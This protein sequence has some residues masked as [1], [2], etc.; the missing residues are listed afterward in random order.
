MNNI[1]T[2]NKLH[3]SSVVLIYCI[4]T[5]F[6]FAAFFCIWPASS[7]FVVYFLLVCIFPFIYFPFRLFSSFN[8]ISYFAHI[9]GHHW[10]E[11]D[12]FCCTTMDTQKLSFEIKWFEHWIFVGIFIEIVSNGQAMHSNRIPGNQVRKWKKN[13]Q[14]KQTRWKEKQLNAE[15]AVIKFIIHIRKIRI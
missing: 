10:I 13:K 5:L 7:S 11:E 6:F 3:F 15:V 1:I 8:S 12:N 2:C 14:M 9:F 4:F